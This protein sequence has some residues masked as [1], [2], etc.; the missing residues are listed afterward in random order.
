MAK[1]QSGEC[2]SQGCLRVLRGGG[3]NGVS[4]EENGGK[5]RVGVQGFNEVPPRLLTFH[6]RPKHFSKNCLKKLNIYFIPARS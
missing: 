6:N 4:R 5:D 3:K 2:K 1:G